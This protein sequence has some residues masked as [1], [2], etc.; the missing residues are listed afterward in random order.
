MRT[1]SIKCRLRPLVSKR[2]HK[3]ED[4]RSLPPLCF[5]FQLASSGRNH[6]RGPEYCLIHIVENAVH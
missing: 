3:E 6:Y 5:A 1:F 4:E 2:N